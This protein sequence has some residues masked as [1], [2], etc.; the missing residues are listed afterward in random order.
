[1]SALLPASPDTAGTDDRRLPFVLLG[2]GCEGLD[3]DFLV[4]WVYAL[5]FLGTC[6]ASCCTENTYIEDE[7]RAV[8][9]EMIE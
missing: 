9:I 1:M 7:R 5:P 8:N 4:P 2:L 6:A 3:G